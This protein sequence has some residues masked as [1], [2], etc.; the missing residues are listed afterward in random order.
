MMGALLSVLTPTAVSAGLGFFAKM[1]AWKASQE[2]EHRKMT[3]LITRAGFDYNGY[4]KLQAGNDTADPLAR[5]SRV[6]IVFC[7]TLTWCWVIVFLLT[8]QPAIQMDVMV[9]VTTPWFMKIFGLTQKADQKT[10]E[11]SAYSLL[12]GFKSMYEFLMVYHFVKMGK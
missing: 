7:F 10:L 9:P 2:M 3:D 6:F 11:V 1:F 8:H 12:W 4:A 5:W